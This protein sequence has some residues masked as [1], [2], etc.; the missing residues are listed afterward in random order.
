VKTTMM[1]GSNWTRRAGSALALAA[2]LASLTA[3]GVRRDLKPKLADGLPPA[4]YGRS[5]RP[6]S[7]ELLGTTSQQRPGRN[8]ELRVQ[9]EERADDPFDLPPTN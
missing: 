4:P 5:D 7:A 6:G 8:V 9:S 2:A 1:A 3:C